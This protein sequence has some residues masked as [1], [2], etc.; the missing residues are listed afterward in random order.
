MKFLFSSKPLITLLMVLAFLG[1]TSA[2]VMMSCTM[3]M[4][5]FDTTTMSASIHHDMTAMSDHTQMSS[6]ST[7]DDKA[8]SNCCADS[9]D[10]TAMSCTQASIVSHSLEPLFAYT[11]ESHLQNN[12]LPN[13]QFLSY[14]FKPPI[15]A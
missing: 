3:E 4:N 9:C 14:L 15:A 13:Q 6:M 11:T 5:S 7:R 12:V 1:Q 10:C 2:S 8:Q